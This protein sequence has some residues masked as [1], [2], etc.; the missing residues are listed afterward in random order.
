M[1]EPLDRIHLHKAPTPKSRLQLRRKRSGNRDVQLELVEQ[2]GLQV[3]HFGQSPCDRIGVRDRDDVV[4]F[5][6]DREI[7]DDGVVGLDV[8]HCPA[9]VGVG[10]VGGD[11]VGAVGEGAGGGGGWGFGRCRGRRG[12]WGG[13]GG[14]RGFWFR[15]LGRRG[16]LA[17]R[18]G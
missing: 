2:L 3:G 17:C 8:I 10:A 1:I 9:E 5:A 16:R 15:R 11:F 14:G 13:G 12:G 18:R 7:R 6:F 4:R